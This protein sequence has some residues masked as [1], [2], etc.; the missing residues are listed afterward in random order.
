[1]RV[2]RV[3]FDH[4]GETPIGPYRVEDLRYRDRYDALC[5][6][7]DDLGSD[8]MDDEHPSPWFEPALGHYIADEECCCFT[9][10]RR[11]RSWFKGW[12]RKLHEVGFELWVYEVP[13]EYVRRG[14]YQA[15]FEI[16]E[17]ALVER[18]PLVDA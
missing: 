10:L 2:Y 9:S 11:M 6:V 12:R 5:D 13:E 1:M 3:A 16:D 17:A 15:V 8:H 7:S 18:R 14:D 4:G